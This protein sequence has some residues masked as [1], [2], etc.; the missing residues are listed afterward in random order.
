MK[1]RMLS[2]EELKVFEEDLKHFLIANGIDGSEWEK[3]NKNDPD[4]AVDL[5]GIFSDAVLQK[6]YEKVR[7]LE[8]RSAQ[9]CFVF[10]LRQDKIELIA[11]QRNGQ[12]D[13]STPESIHDALTNRLAELQFF[14]SEKGYNL[15]REAEIHK[16][17]TDGCVPSHEAFWMQLE[18]ALE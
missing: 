8:F 14:R 18:K 13:L 15:N 7:F 17:I 6:V 2:D 5:V 4:K 9:S 12:V 11:I 16:M 3:I 10:K 1:F